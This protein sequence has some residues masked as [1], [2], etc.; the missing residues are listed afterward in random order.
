[1]LRLSYQGKNRLKKLG[2][3]LGILVLISAL[4][5][6]CWLIWLQRFIVFTE[7][8]VVFDFQ[9]STLTLEDKTA[10]DAARE[11][12]ALNIRVNDGEDTI[13]ST[14][15]ALGQISGVYVDTDMLLEGIPTIE[16]ALEAIDPGTAIMLD[17]KSK[18]GN[19]YY[20]TSIQGASQSESINSAEMDSLIRTLVNKGH[21]LIARLPAFRDSAFAKEHQHCGLALSSGVLWTDE[22]KCYWLDPANDTVQSNLIQ[23]C[24]EL[25]DLGFHEVVFSDFKIP[26]SGSIVYSAGISKDQVLKQAAERL[27]S[28]CAGSYFTVSFLSTTDFPLPAGYTR[29][30]LENI[31]PEQLHSTIS[32]APGQDTLTQTVFLTQTRDTRYDEYCVLRALK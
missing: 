11:T 6:V 5:L 27:V 28:T 18:F 12:L 3:A 31:A 21:Y 13:I 9:R 20:T 10:S 32:K 16:E 26:D 14:D 1:M 30:Y 8:G 17:V 24:R 22:D 25:R 4:L 2:I 19:F 7:D 23:I 15:K 29:L